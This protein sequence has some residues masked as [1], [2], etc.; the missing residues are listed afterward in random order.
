MPSA[1]FPVEDG[2]AELI[3]CT[4]DDDDNDDK[5]RDSGVKIMIATKMNICLIGLSKNTSKSSLDLQDKFHC[6]CRC[7]CI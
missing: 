6:Q 4:D 5:E 7:S 2:A 3:G 1:M